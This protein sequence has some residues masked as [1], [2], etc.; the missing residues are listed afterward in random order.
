MTGPTVP[1]V[2]E[3]RVDHLLDARRA[4][5]SPAGLNASGD[6]CRAAAVTRGLAPPRGGDGRAEIE[7]MV[8]SGLVTWRCRVADAG[9]GGRVDPLALGAGLVFCLVAGVRCRAGC[10]ADAWA[11]G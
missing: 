4:G 8:I 6:R 11:P 1:A 2:R 10:W 9:A 7:L 5:Q 3:G